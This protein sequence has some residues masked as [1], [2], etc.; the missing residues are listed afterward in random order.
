M[1]CDPVNGIERSMAD[2]CPKHDA[3]TTYPHYRRHIVRARSL[4]ALAKLHAPDDLQRAVLCME[5]HSRYRAAHALSPHDWITRGTATSPM[6]AP[7]YLR[8]GLNV[9]DIGRLQLF[10]S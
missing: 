10:A 3:N 2:I 8:G 5:K 9:P 7:L 4:A 6:E 1:E